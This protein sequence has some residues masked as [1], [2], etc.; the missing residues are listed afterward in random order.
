M[1]NRI[2]E[3]LSKLNTKIIINTINP[4]FCD[5]LLYSEETNLIGYGWRVENDD[6]DVSF[7]SSQVP[8]RGG[9]RPWRFDMFETGKFNF[10][11]S[12]EV[13]FRELLNLFQ[14]AISDNS[15]WFSVPVGYLEMGYTCKPLN[16]IKIF[17]D[18][19]KLHITKDNKDEISVFNFRKEDFVNW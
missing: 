19:I 10:E 9:V 1:I 3:Q 6:L 4:K 14:F 15:Y 7:M 8:G 18:Y 11:L 13:D 12:A 2:N 5:Y 17:E 16:D